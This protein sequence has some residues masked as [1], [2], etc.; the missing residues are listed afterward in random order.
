MGLAEEARRMIGILGQSAVALLMGLFFVLLLSKKITTAMR[1]PS[2]WIGE[3]VI[4]AAT[5]IIIFRYGGVAAVAL[6]VTSLFV[7]GRIRLG[8]PCEGL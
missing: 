1:S 8:L 5:I 3:A 7:L 6:W 2:G 4:A